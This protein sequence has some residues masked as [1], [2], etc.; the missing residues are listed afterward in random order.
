MVMISIASPPRRP[1]AFVSA[2]P[3]GVSVSRNDEHLKQGFENYRR[4]GTKDRR[5]RN[6]RI[7][8]IDEHH[9][10]AH[11]AWTAIYDPGSEPDVSIDFEVHYLVQQLE[12]APK[13][14]G[15][16]SGHEQ[17]VLKRTW[18]HLIPTSYP[19][20]PGQRMSR[21]DGLGI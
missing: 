11:V 4:I 1:A 18:D 10:M 20:R 13:I 8:P 16:V 17:A 14:F 7:S 19:C 2:S 9:C 12:G 6:V 15:W 3:A 21:R 5:L